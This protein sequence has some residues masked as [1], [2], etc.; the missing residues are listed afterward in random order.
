MESYDGKKTV[1]K[2]GAISDYI[3]IRTRTGQL[4]D[5]ICVEEN[6]HRTVDLVL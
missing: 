6:G 1:R 5:Y 2:L 4:A 3:K